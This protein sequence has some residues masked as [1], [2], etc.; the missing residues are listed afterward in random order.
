MKEQP[1]PMGV[2]TA[3]GCDSSKFIRVNGMDK[4]S[5]RA[6]KMTTSGC[7]LRRFDPLPEGDSCSEG[8][9]RS[10]GGDR[11]ADI[12]VARHLISSG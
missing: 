8:D 1:E 7:L 5:G 4:T 9:N 10:H 12:K 3:S 11:R 2:I 6:K